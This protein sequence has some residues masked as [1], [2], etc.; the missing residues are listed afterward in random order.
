MTLRID[1]KRPDWRE[2]ATEEYLERRDALA[3]RRD[4]AESTLISLQKKIATLESEIA[5]LDRSARVFGLTVPGE[6]GERILFTVQPSGHISGGQFK[7]VALDYLAEVYPTPK[8]AIDVQRFV[9]ATLGRSFH[10]KTAGMTLYRL[11][12]EHKVRR[13]GPRLWAFVPEEERVAQRLKDEIEAA[14]AK[15]TAAVFYPDGGK[16]ADQWLIEPDVRPPAKPEE[17]P[18]G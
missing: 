3:R 18:F 11:K 10:W 2:P 5:E 13:E 14:R 1:H 15:E 17:D 6:D 16:D 12:N 7:D 4:K 9:E 8:R